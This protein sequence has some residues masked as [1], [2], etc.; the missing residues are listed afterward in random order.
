MIDYKGKK[1]D[2]LNNFVF[3]DYLIN[4]NLNE[5]PH[6]VIFTNNKLHLI[7]SNGSYSNC[8]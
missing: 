6:T 2:R 5:E 1:Y 4:H 7:F 8:L 3:N